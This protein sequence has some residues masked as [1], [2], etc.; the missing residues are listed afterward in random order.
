MLFLPA[1][2]A[3]IL[4]MREILSDAFVDTLKFMPVLMICYLLIEY[5]EHHG[6]E[7]SGALISADPRFSVVLGSLV[8]LIPQCGFSV[9]AASLYSRRIIS[10]GT[11]LAVFIATSDEAML[12]LISA[13]ALKDILVILAGKFL[14][15]LAV[16][17]L[18]DRFLKHGGHQESDK[19]L[20]YHEEHCERGIVGEAIHHTLEISLYILI[21]NIVLNA[22]FSLLSEQ[23]LDRLLLQGSCMQVLLTA[24]IGLFPNCAASVFIGSLYLKGTI[25][26][27]AFFAG[28]VTVSG[29]GYA[30]LLKSR[31]KS[32]LM[33]ILLILLTGIAA[34]SLLYC[35]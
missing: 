8:G 17:L 28:L 20:S 31:T 10:L 25:S 13:G 19:L 9:A 16:G 12:M 22:A 30:A 21:C 18:A 4:I 1:Q 27:A 7:G 2:C 14:L 33:I 29:L 24:L 15:A 23:L 3:R 35:F 6:Q 34:G 32:S 5:S 26:F 11:L